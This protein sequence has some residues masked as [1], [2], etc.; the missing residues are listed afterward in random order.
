MSEIQRF[1]A[2]KNIASWVSEAS[3]LAVAATPFAYRKAR[4]VYK[5]GV[6]TLEDNGTPYSYRPE[7]LIYTAL[8]LLEERGSLTPEELQ[9]VRENNVAFRRL[10]MKKG[11]FSNDDEGIMEAFK[12]Y[13]V[14]PQDHDEISTQRRTISEVIGDTAVGMGIGL[15][16]LKRRKSQKE[17]PGSE[18]RA[19][20][21]WENMSAID[22]LTLDVY[23]LHEIIRR[24][25]SV[26][27]YTF[28]TPVDHFDDPEKRK[29][30]L[31]RSESVPRR[32]IYEMS[33]DVN[34]ET[35]LSEETTA[36]DME[37]MG[38]QKSLLARVNEIWRQIL[39]YVM[40]DNADVE[41]FTFKGEVEE[42][43][44]IFELQKVLDGLRNREIWDIQK[45]EEIDMARV[46]LLLYISAKL[47]KDITQYKFKHS[48][49]SYLD[50]YLTE[51]VFKIIG[52]EEV[53]AEAVVAGDLRAGK[54]RPPVKVK[55][56]R[57]EI[58]DPDTGETMKVYLYQGKDSEHPESEHFQTGVVNIKSL[59]K[60]IL[61]ML[62]SREEPIDIH[63][64]TVMPVSSSSEDLAK[65]RRILEKTI[66]DPKKL[67]ISAFKGGENASSAYDKLDIRT[68]CTTIVPEV[69]NGRMMVDGMVPDIKKGPPINI[70]RIVFEV[71][72]GPRK[73]ILAEKHPDDETHHGLYA[74]V[75]TLPATNRL[76]NPER[77]P[78]NW[79]GRAVQVLER[80]K[81]ALKTGD[82]VMPGW[83]QT[84]VMKKILQRRMLRK[85]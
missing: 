83:V 67:H 75:R 56:V 26:V 33:K 66:L 82:D 34:P 15:L 7:E 60:I 79:T 27:E 64:I 42:A 78:E 81:E 71:R 1:R 6:K 14:K 45:L 18:R 69:K 31:R 39:E 51:N 5:R 2:V 9:F 37:L 35:D 24:N 77:H 76:L 50:K 13:M 65:M 43:E 10:I 3:Q 49:K 85:K 30:Y 20:I 58:T 25:P 80:M 29:R 72:T 28:P 41:K 11:G 21:K 32:K 47:T 23:K 38:R 8:I 52:E 84:Q 54:L 4:N 70:S 16:G 17:K 22:L 19:I 73:E 46:K 68:D 36:E 57:A 40:D 48:I 55:V 53:D 74:R 12:P 59:A 44:S 62:T 61:K 63:R